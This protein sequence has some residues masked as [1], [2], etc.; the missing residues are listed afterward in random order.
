MDLHDD[1]PGD[2]A[3]P[4]DLRCEGCGADI[5]APDKLFEVRNHAFVPHAD[6]MLTEIHCLS[7][8]TRNDAAAWIIDRREARKALETVRGPLDMTPASMALLDRYL[9]MVEGYRQQWES[10]YRLGAEDDWREVDFSG[11][12]PDLSGRRG[13]VIPARA[14]AAARGCRKAAAAHPDEG[15]PGALRVTW[16]NC[17]LSL[18][19]MPEAR[20]PYALHLSVHNTLTSGALSEV[21]QSFLLSLV[22]TPGEVPFV[23]TEP[24]ESDPLTHFYLGSDSTDLNEC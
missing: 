4:F 1:A 19:E 16:F 8:G 20:Q 5:N 23:W 6:Y 13:V 22:F 15:P 24:G 12:D 11:I 2:E 14:L 3:V 18:D 9:R 10:F 21:Q 17:V 7:C